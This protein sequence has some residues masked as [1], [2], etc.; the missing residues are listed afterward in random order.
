MNWKSQPLEGVFLEI[1]EQIADAR[2]IAL[3]LDYD[4]T[5]APIVSDPCE[6]FMEAGT[7]EALGRISVLDRITTSIISGRALDDLRPRVGIDSFLYAGNH[8]LEIAGPGWSFIEPAAA[9]RRDELRAISKVLSK[10]LLAIDGVVVEYKGLTASVHYRNAED[11]RFPEI[12]RIMKA[13]IP[14]EFRMRAGRKVLEI[15]PAADWNKGTAVRFILRRLGGTPLPIYIGDDA[16][17]EDAFREIPD[18][19]TV[20]A[21]L[22]GTTA[23]RYRVPDSHAVSALLVMLGSPSGTGAW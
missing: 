2:N 19:V 1:R 18:G 5:L 6:A 4:G 14:P 23:A 13:V 9:V 20:K 16:T 10:R 11:A 21:G 8:G 17:D 3:F 15:L 7:A 22:V 12:E